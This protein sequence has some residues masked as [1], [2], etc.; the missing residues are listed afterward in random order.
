MCQHGK[1]IG[2]CDLE[3]PVGVRLRLYAQHLNDLSTVA[4]P[5]KRYYHNAEYEV[6]VI[7]GS[8]DS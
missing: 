5:L 7:N 4:L 8:G 3:P 1:H 2:G 6:M